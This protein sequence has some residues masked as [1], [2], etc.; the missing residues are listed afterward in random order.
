VLGQHS[1]LP[2]YTIG[3]RKG[4]GIPSPEP[5]Y[6]LGV[7][8]DRNALIVGTWAELGTD[9]L[10]AARVNWV[11]GEPPAEPFRAQVKIR[12]KAQPAPA[13][14]EPLPEARAAARFDE[15]L[16]AITPGQGAVFYDGEVCLG[17]G[18]IERP[19]R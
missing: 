2:D 16:P 7:D 6:V 10:T 19:A 11:A 9:R 5:L 8:P 17:G 18:I 14:V 15:P 3:Q 13:V 4:L 1:G 12:Y